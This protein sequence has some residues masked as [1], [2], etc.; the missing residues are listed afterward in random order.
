MPGR[1]LSHPARSTDPSSRSAII[2]VSTESAMTSR[3]TREKCIPSCPIEMPSETEMVPNSRG[4]PP[5][6]C[7]PFLT[8][9]AN[10]S[11]ERLQGVISFQLDAT[12]ICGLAK[13]SSPMP[14][15][16]SM[17]RA[18]AFSR[19]SVTSRLRGLRSGGEVF[20]LVMAGSLRP[21]RKVGPR[22]HI[23]D[24]GGLL[25]ASAAPLVGDDDPVQGLPRREPVELGPQHPYRAREEGGRRATDVRAD[26]HAG[27]RPER[28]VRRQRLGVGDVEG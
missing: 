8:A 10:R 13:S 25:L 21:V 5:P 27:R 28:V 7:T 2:T 3:E 18:A 1:D 20:G 15:A 16:R 19:P 23:P 11:S 4:K 17:P 26:Q 24:D 14:T 9:F 12:P 22:S 6:A